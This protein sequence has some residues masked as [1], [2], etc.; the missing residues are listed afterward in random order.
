[1]VTDSVP[2]LDAASCC[3]FPG[4]AAAEAAGAPSNPATRRQAMLSR[5]IARTLILDGD[6][7][8][9]VDDDIEVPSVA[10]A[11]RYSL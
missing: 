6:T 2:T 1:M 4:L 7:G 8:A 11:V 5:A 10:C 9:Q 3:G